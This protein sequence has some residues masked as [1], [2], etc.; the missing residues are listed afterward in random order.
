VAQAFQAW[1]VFCL[2]VGIVFKKENPGASILLYGATAVLSVVLLALVIQLWQADWKVPIG[3]VP[4]DLLLHAE[5]VK[6][7]LDNGWYYKNAF[8]GAPGE[9]LF[10]DFPYSPNLPMAFLKVLSL[11]F[12]NY[13][14][15]LN[16]YFVLGF[17]LIAL[18]ALF[19]FRRFGVSPAPAMLASLL[20]SLL[21]YH[22]LRGENHLFYS[23]YFMVPLAGMVA[24]ELCRGDLVVGRTPW[25]ARIPPDPPLRAMVSP[26]FLA[27]LV[28]CSLS[29][30]DSPYYSFFAV[31][32]CA[33]AGLYAFVGRTPRSA[34]DPP[35]A[36]LRSPLV[37][38]ALLIASIFISAELNIA[39]A[40]IHKWR[41]GANSHVATRGDVEAEVF[42]LKI[43][44][45]LLPMT[46]HRLPA[47]SSLKQQYN[48][49]APLVNQENDAESLGLIGSA[50]FLILIGILLSGKK[51]PLLTE[52]SLLN[53]TAILLG[54][55]AGFGA[56]I[57]FAVLP[58]VRGYARISIYIAW[59]SFFAVAFAIDQAFRRFP[60]LQRFQ[61]PLCGALL[62]FGVRDQTSP[63]FVPPYAE[64][65][66]EFHNN[67]DFVSRIEEALPQGSM[68]FQ[69]PYMFFPENGSVNLMPDYSH[70]HGYLNSRKLRWSYGVM[71]GR[72][73]DEWQK[74]ISAKPP[75]EMVRPL[76]LRGFAGIYIDRFGYP[77]KGKAIESELGQALGSGPLLESENKR[78]AFF[79]LLPFAAKWKAGTPPEKWLQLEKAERERLSL[80]WTGGFSGLEVDSFKRWRWC[81]SKGTLVFD[82]PASETREMEISTRLA[83][84]QPG[85]A[86]LWI[87]GLFS[88]HLKISG[89]GVLYH[90][91][92]QVPPGAHQ[93]RFSCDAPRVIAP[94]DS[95]QLVFTM[96]NF[97]CRD[98]SQGKP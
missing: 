76:V 68:V 6:A 28:T 96:E 7:M 9:L 37:A 48:Q 40:L 80:F 21:P 95:R 16:I 98:V 70:L 29:A 85:E 13:A 11:F 56:L 18:A 31:F 15:L 78:L 2:I 73:I 47:L 42:G 81:A 77:D 63:A 92:F 1:V 72:P 25:S 55:I 32:F 3:P 35:V 38:A 50:G 17:P 83:T 59:F 49:L 51:W 4:P 14:T 34:G 94:S 24:L 27:A 66:N 53:L 82:N 52:L 97:Q 22:F 39:P 41:Y 46:N 87:E 58:L 36:L 64:I 23:A 30:F 86:N 10:L 5:I 67:R 45:L 62:L 79:S 91:V 69:L 8:L 71:R 88:D 90:K 93:L 61:W 75:S 12:S 44:Q 43:D 74:E 57:S 26:K 33:T 20:F 60:R 54:T 65:R 84:G 19:S 89:A